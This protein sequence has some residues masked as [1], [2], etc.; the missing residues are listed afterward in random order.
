MAIPSAEPGE[1]HWPIRRGLAGS[2]MSRICTPSVPAATYAREP[3]T[4]TS[5]TASPKGGVD[6]TSRGD[7]E[8][9]TS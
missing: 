3:F 8:S 4:T 6:P 9:A 5:N 2:E 7:E 1:F